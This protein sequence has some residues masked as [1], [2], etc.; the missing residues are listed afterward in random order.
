MCFVL[1][2][3]L[4]LTLANYFFRNQVILKLHLSLI[5]LKNVKKSV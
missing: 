4:S 5:G 2:E 1:I 3:F